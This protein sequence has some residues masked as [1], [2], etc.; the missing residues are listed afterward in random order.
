MLQQPLC[1]V[2]LDQ[3]RGVRYLLP[4]SEEWTIIE[5]LIAVLKP[6][7]RATTAMSASSYPTLSMLSPL[8][9]KLLEKVL[10]VE[11]DD[12]P[13]GKALKEAIL[14]DLSRRYSS[15]NQQVMLHAA[16]FLD[17]RFKD[18]DPFVPETERK[19]VQ[20]SVK[21]EMLDLAVTDENE[22]QSKADTNVQPSN[23]ESQEGPPPSKKPKP[24]TVSRFFS[25][26]SGAKAARKHASGYDRVKSEVD[27]YIQ[28]PLL[29][30]DDDPL[31]WWK[32][33]QSQYPLMSQ[34]VRKYWS[35]TATSVRSEEPFSTAGNVLTKKRNRLLPEN[36]DKLVF[37]HDNM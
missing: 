18:L 11:E 2:L 8:L 25:D 17:P 35:L 31:E 28:E 24:G 34:L 15:L 32:S 6:F 9:Y 20:E 10:R 27:R 30:L 22:T 12:T 5:E 4:D 19:D 16:A 7:H 37:L 3:P 29:D 13:S 26:L 33:R 14:T 21:L 23:S 36:V 1:A